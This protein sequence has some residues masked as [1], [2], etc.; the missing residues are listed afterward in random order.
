LRRWLLREDSAVLGGSLLVAGRLLV[1]VFGWAGTILIV[2]RLSEED[3]G[4]FALVFGVLGVVATFTDLQLSRVV[5]RAL[6]EG[7]STVP[8]SYLAF[9]FTLSIG[10]YLAAVVF[11]LLVY[12]ESTLETTAV[13]GVLLLFAGTSSA[14]HV[15]LQER[16]FL[17]P[18]ALGLVVGQAVQFG[19]ILAL[20][21]AGSRD[22]VAFALPAVVNEVIHL[23][24]LLLV[25]RGHVRLLPTLQLRRWLQWAREAAI[26]AVGFILATVQTRTGLVI[27]SKM[28]DLSSVGQYAVA[29]K[30]NDLFAFVPVAL[31]APGLTLLV[32][33]WPD[34]RQAFAATFDKLLSTLALLGAAGVVAFVVLAKPLTVTFYGPQFESATASAQLL[35]ASEGLHF[36]TSVYLVTLLAVGR[37]R[38]YVTVAVASFATNIVLAILLIPLWSHRGAAVADLVAEVVAILVAGWALSRADLDIAVAP[39]EVWKLLAV[40]T[41]T[42]L[43]ALVVR[44]AYS[45]FFA[46]VVIGLS[47]VMMLWSLR[48]LPHPVPRQAPERSA[49]PTPR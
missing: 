25:L 14:L 24:V 3:W 28:D 8:G 17:R 26:L 12:D 2:R 6:H 36:V 39:R 32:R 42:I 21:L 16:L 9:R 15:V 19:V 30:F 23:V 41:W 13:A 29:I 33:S 10:G 47:F 45:P 35:M 46:A 22:P 27:L 11:A 40:T 43:S 20:F 1:A 31:L 7:D 38:P 48:L 5:L 4:R 34:D 44:G 18:I 49:Y 37:A